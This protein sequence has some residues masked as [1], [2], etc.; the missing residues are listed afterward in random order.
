MKKTSLVL[1]AALLVA[2]S[3]STTYLLTY[4][5]VYQRVKEE[6]VSGKTV[7]ENSEFS[8]FLT[9]VSKYNDLYIREKD[10]DFDEIN[11]TLIR[12]YLAMTG[13]L[14][15]EYYTPEMLE[16]LLT[17]M[18]GKLVGIGVVVAQDPENSALVILA[19]A[20]DSPA[21]EAGLVPGD[22]IVGVQTGNGQKTIAEIGLSNASSYVRG[23][24]GTT[25]DLTV[26]RT[27]DGETTEEILTVTRREVTVTKIIR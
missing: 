16:E 14:Y 5:A 6:Y 2:L 24:A 17:S 12:C 9:T 11:E 7:A 21:A 27:K 13:D 25:V 18:D 3:V 19:V 23:E 4:H 1:L 10:L 26:R 15:N 8:K 20:D 22:A